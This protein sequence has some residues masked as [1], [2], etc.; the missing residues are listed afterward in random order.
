MNFTVN[1]VPQVLKDHTDTRWT[2]HT[3]YNHYNGPM[4]FMEDCLKQEEHK[5]AQEK[6]Q[7]LRDGKDA[8]KKIHEKNA[9]YDTLFENVSEQ[10]RDKLLTRGFTTAMLYSTVEFTNMNTGV[11]SKQRAMLGKRDCFFKNPSVSDGKLFHD[12]YINL[13]Y[14]WSI[15]DRVIRE[16]SYALYAL[17]KALAR[18]IPM[19]VIVVNHVGTDTPTCY[20]YILKQ[21]GQPIKPEEF[22]FFTSESKRTFGWFTYGLLNKGDSYDSTVGEPEGSVSIDKFNLDKVID[23]VFLKI[24]KVN[25]ALFKMK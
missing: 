1:Q 9:K 7:Y 3:I 6:I 14:N 16:N 23:D 21:F 2:D 5:D 10:V 13:S 22:L 15:E 17:T 20:S 25:P 19:R 18:V 24:S 4:E 8:Y 11:M 12:L